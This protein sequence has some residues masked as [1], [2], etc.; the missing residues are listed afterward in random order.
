MTWLVLFL[1]LEVGMVSGNTQVLQTGM[2]PRGVYEEPAS[3]VYVHID[4]EV[5]LFGV[6]FFGGGIENYQVPMSITSWAPHRAI[7]FA[8]A[9]VRYKWFELGV[10]HYCDHPVMSPGAKLRM[11]TAGEQTKIYFKIT[12]QIGGKS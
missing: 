6:I 7:Y 1:T 3:S 9:G 4:A 8:R 2:F 11:Y 12:G 5:Q 10:R